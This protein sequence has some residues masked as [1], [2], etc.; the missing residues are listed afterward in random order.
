M[1]DVWAHTSKMV[2][3]KETLD[4][5]SRN[6]ACHARRL[7]AKFG[8]G[9]LAFAAGM[10]HDL[11]KAKTAFQAY[12]RNERGSYPH[13]AD[14]ALFADRAFDRKDKP[15][16]GRALAFVIAGHHAGLANGIDPGGGTS[17]LRERLE[18][19]A[20]ETQRP[21]LW[22]DPSEIA[23]GKRLS[24]L[25]KRDDASGPFAKAFFIRML[26]SVL[27]DADFVETDRWYAKVERDEKVERGWSGQASGSLGPLR[28][29]LDAHLTTFAESRTDIDHLRAEVLADCRAAAIVKPPGHFTLTVPT[30]GGKTLSSL[31]F[32]L[33]HA[34]EHS[35]DRVIYVIPFTSIAEQTASEFRKALKDDDAIL[36]H[37]SAFDFESLER[38]KEDAQDG[39]KQIRRAAENWERPV[40]VTTAVQFFESL[41]SNRTSRCRKLHNI[42]R[43]VIVLDE[44]QTLP[45]PLLRPCLAVLKELTRGYGSS[46]VLCT[47]TQPAV[48]KEA[49]LTA[50]EGLEA[51]TEIIKPGRELFERLKRVRWQDGGVMSDGHIT[52][53]LTEVESGLVIVNN[54]R[55]ARELFEHLKADDIEGA[56]LLTTAM[57]AAHRQKVLEEIRADLDPKNANR[58]PVRLI[59]TSLIEAGVDVSFKSAW[60]A[61]AGL[62]QI[63]QAAG[64]CNRSGEFG[65]EG[66]TLTIFEPEPGEGR[67]PPRETKTNADAGRSV[68]NRGC[69][70]LSPEGTAAYFEE[71]LWRKDDGGHWKALDNKEVGEA[72]VPGVMKALD[73]KANGLN[74]PFADIAKAFRI[75][76][77]VM[78]PVIIPASISQRAGID[79]SIRYRIEAVAARKAD[80]SKAGKTG[81]LGG[82]LRDLQRHVVQVP[83]RIRDGVLAKDVEAIA[84][85]LFGEQFVMLKTPALYGDEAGLKMDDPTW[86]SAE[87]NV[88]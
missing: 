6:V 33:E 24:Q 14:G 88:M 75:I 71:L 56:R 15:G 35:L 69:D 37:H 9:D 17:P 79:D 34:I 26:F 63:A 53:A 64:R 55:H 47:A 45:V 77:D 20:A 60:R 30:G 82:I 21:E 1:T 54:R 72:K 16:L 87:S 31:A 74:F 7:G 51:V 46:V 13:S 8:A 3:D 5:H 11:G 50:P 52:A 22:F 67:N 61:W 62:D 76:D 36:E 18:Q 70:P 66:G 42:T 86:R 43:S 85:N 44:A 27:V 49:G 39:A 28:D 10:L 48:T 68:V 29:A 84:P 73:D 65:H 81:G 12:L 40:V 59:A 41:F 78:V 25:G 4:E 80:P 2:E 19:A 83:R 38:N 23:I 32:A 57:T 58:K